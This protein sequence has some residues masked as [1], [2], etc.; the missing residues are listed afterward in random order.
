MT[1]IDKITEIL[2][3]HDEVEQCTS[4]GDTTT[5]LHNC[6]VHNCSFPTKKLEMR[7]WDDQAENTTNTELRGSIKLPGKVKNHEIHSKLDPYWTSRAE[8]QAF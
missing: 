8:T 4:R 6:S 5:N 1:K 7:F 3:W 2:K